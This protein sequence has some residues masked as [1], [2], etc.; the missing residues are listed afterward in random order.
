MPQRPLVTIAM[1]C[2]NEEGFI[3]ACLDSVRRQDYPSD[4]LEILVADG[5]STDRTREILD[6]LARGDSRLRV[7]SNPDRLQAAGLNAMIRQARGD[8]VVRMDVH[9]EYAFDYV[10]RCVETLER[11]GADNVGG[12][13]RARGRTFFQRAVCAAVRSP[14][15]VGGAAYRSAEN[16]GEVETVFL[17]AYP[18]RVLETIGLYDPRAFTNEDAELNQRIL[19]AGGKIYLS[20]DIVVHYYPRASFT[21]L[22]RQYFRYGQGR[23]RTLLKHGRLRSLRPLLPFSLV[24][25]GL[26]LVALPWSR[27]LT[28][29]AFAA[30]ALVVAAEAGRVSRLDSLA[31]A[32]LVALI[33]PTLLV[34][35]GVGFIVGLIRFVTRP[36]WGPTERISS[37][38]AA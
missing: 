11:T 26:V 6:R 9:C 7:I 25:A 34:S 35:H 17:G 22:A 12:A 21:A 13:Q 16:E 29:W 27:P 5:G 2:L 36:D 28:P 8:I 37:G 33:F 1:P 4:R 10:R 23:A 15:G 3:E 32:P 14:L 20:R 24:M 30:Y 18:R 31:L 38:S 19:E